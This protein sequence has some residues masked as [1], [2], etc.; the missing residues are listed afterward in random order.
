MLQE[1]ADHAAEWSRDVEVAGSAQRRTNQRQRLEQTY[2]GLWRPRSPSL[3]T[4][5]NLH[6]VLE[7]AKAV[8]EITMTALCFTC[9]AKKFDS[10]NR[11]SARDMVPTADDEFAWSLG[12]SD[13]YLPADVLDM[14]SRLVLAGGS[15][16]PLPP[17]AEAKI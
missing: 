14:T 11:C 16:P 5:G 12:F 1:R 4:N 6:G 9:G 15:R 3:A 2:V 8:A 17:D 13:H 10:Y 7:E